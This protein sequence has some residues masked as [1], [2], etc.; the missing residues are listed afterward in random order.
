MLTASASI[1]PDGKNNSAPSSNRP[2]AI[3][4]YASHKLLEPMAS[5]F[6]SGSE[7]LLN[8]FL[9]DD[10]IPLNLNDLHTRAGHDVAA[11]GDHVHE[12]IPKLNLARRP[13]GR[14]RHAHGAE[15]G[16]DLGT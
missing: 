13:Q 6:S 5:P 2:T 3:N 11:L 12:L 9:N 7:R 10:A 4:T 16:G 8:D 1:T 15:Q 14:G